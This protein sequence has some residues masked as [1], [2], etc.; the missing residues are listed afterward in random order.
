MLKASKCIRRHVALVPPPVQIIHLQ[1]QCKRKLNFNIKYLCSL[2][3]VNRFI[4]KGTLENKKLFDFK[5][6]SPLD[7]LRIINHLTLPSKLRLFY[8]LSFIEKICYSILVCMLS[9]PTCNLICNRI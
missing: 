8:R 4:T 5:A 9:N 3:Q 6:Q 1:Q 7:C 2:G